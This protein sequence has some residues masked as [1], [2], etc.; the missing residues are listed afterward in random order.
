M[1][2]KVYF[3][4]DLHLGSKIFS[5]HREREQFIINW[6]N[7]IKKDCSALYLLGDIFDFWFEYKYVVPK[8]HLRFLAK[9]AEFT[10]E[11]IPVHFFSGNHDVWAFGYLHDEC[12]VI[13]H[14]SKTEICE[15]DGLKI[16]LGHGDGLDTKD[17][18]YLFLRY[19]FH[20]KFTQ[21]LFKWIHP[22]FSFAFAFGSSKKSRQKGM[23]SDN[24]KYKDKGEIEYCNS[25][26]KNEHID[27]F[28]FGH[29][30]EPM[31]VKLENNSRY[32]NT[33]DWIRHFTYVEMEGKKLELKYARQQK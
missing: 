26:L 11:G 2:K 15:M 4:S 5:N 13:L 9:L 18:K 32:L 8:G 1:S 30:H 33:G 22:D 7:S 31:D 27:V 25:I 23:R 6:L 19:I 20:A 16:M 17:K 10:D 12:G 24:I 28:I 14:N 21:F 3:I 29:R